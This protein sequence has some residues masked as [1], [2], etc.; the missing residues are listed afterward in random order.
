MRKFG[1]DQSLEL[2]KQREKIKASKELNQRSTNKKVSI[3]S[4]N[5]ILSYRAV[6]MEYTGIKT[7][8]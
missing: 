6:A 3:L 1:R 2:E 5:D 7:Q 4:W 8:N